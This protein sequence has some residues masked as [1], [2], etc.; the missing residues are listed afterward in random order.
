MLPF[1]AISVDRG[2]SQSLHRDADFATKLK[3]HLGTVTQDSDSSLHQASIDVTSELS[4]NDTDVSMMTRCSDEMNKGELAAAATT[5]Q[6]C[7]L[8]SDPLR[9]N[10]IE[11][12][13]SRKRLYSK[14]ATLLSLD[15]RRT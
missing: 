1:P 8:S 10:Y 14:P 12:N 9:H 7:A 3:S 13:K 15:F 4:R 6:I 5:G 2:E 11:P